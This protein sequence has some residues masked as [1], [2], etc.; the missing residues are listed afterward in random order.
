MLDAVL[1]ATK[2]VFSLY[3]LWLL[4]LGV[5]IGQVVAAIP[6]LTGTMAIAI[7]LPVT[8]KLGPIPSL[9]LLIG[10]YKG[11]Q[12]GGSIPAILIGVPGAPEAGA[13]MLDGY[14]LG[15]KGYPLKAMQMALYGSVIS[16]TYSD[17]YLVFLSAPLAPYA[18]MLGPAEKFGLVVF[19]LTLVGAIATEFPARGLLSASIGVLLAMIG[20]DPIIGAPRLTFGSP[21]LLEG[22]SLMPLMLG[23]FAVP[24][25][26]EEARKR[27]V[28]EYGD[29]MAL[30]R[31]NDHLTLRELRGALWT[32]FRSGTVGTFVGAC[33]ALGSA[34]AAFICYGIAKNRSKEPE[35]FGQGHLHG[36]AAAEAGNSGTVGAT[37]I[38]VLTLG[39]PGSGTAALFMAALMIQG[40]P[41]GPQ[42]FAEFPVV[43]YAL[44]VAHL[45]GNVFNW[46]IGEAVIR[47]GRTIV[48]TKPAFLY[49]IVFLLC[50]LGAYGPD[51]RVFDVWLMLVV[52]VAGFLMERCQV[53][54]IPA[55]IGFVLGSLV[56]KS[57]RQAMI[58]FDHNYLLFFTHP[59]VV[60]CLVLSAASAVISATHMR[61]KCR[62]PATAEGGS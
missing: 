4:A 30:R 40:I 34:A 20:M 26:I 46:V 13:T 10:C 62:L 24:Q 16:D 36:I 9:C 8:F 33:P 37:L 61:R 42:I 47:V 39:I 58:I 14:P 45:L 53:P 12:F 7:M 59:F 44:F 1:A 5:I 11:S 57:F 2:A 54:L 19:A 52:G 28:P 3:N 56:E 41:P 32:I 48:R 60:L 15:K 55:I 38:P 25:L 35:Q 17:L 22:M 6:G 18:L 27:F 31:P 49:P 43:V 21:Y 29:L 51:N 23:L 50:L